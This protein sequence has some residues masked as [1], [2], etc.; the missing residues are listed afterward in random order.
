MKY[1]GQGRAVHYL[2][3]L[4]REPLYMVVFALLW[5]GDVLHSLNPLIYVF[6]EFNGFGV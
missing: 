1:P 5:A 6:K 3:M 2:D 4:D